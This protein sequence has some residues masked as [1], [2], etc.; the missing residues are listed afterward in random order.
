[1]IPGDV[2]D[3]EMWLTGRLC[4][5]WTGAVPGDTPWADWGIPCPQP[6]ESSA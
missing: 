4:G 5:R 1:M 6:A 2:A 3:R